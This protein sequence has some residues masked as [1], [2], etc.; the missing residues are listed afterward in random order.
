L[1]LAPESRSV[2]GNGLKLIVKLV[3]TGVD[4]LSATFLFFV[5][6]VHLSKQKTIIPKIVKIKMGFF[7]KM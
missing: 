6:L 1:G 5:G 7:I 4:R 3:S 2:G